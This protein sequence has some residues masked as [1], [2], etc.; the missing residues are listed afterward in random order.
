MCFGDRV[1]WWNIQGLM[2]LRNKCVGRRALTVPGEDAEGPLSDA[3]SLRLVHLTLDYGGGEGV[4]AVLLRHVE[5]V[6]ALGIVER[7]IHRLDMRE[8]GVAG[9]AWVRSVEPCP[10]LEAGPGKLVTGWFHHWRGVVYDLRVEGEPEPIRVTA[11][12]PYRRREPSPSTAPSRASDSTTAKKSEV[13][14]APVYGS[15]AQTDSRFRRTRRMMPETNDLHT[16]SDAVRRSAPIC[17]SPSVLERRE[18]EARG[19]MTSPETNE[20]RNRRSWE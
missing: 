6:Q 15:G 18:F 20:G 9:W 8:M 19:A 7:A 2:E 10:P 17:P 13:S 5:E 14:C 11:L 1:R 16:R 4:D 3:R 12:H